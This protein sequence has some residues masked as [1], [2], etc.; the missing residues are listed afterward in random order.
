[1]MTWRAQLPDVRDIPIPVHDGDT[2]TADVDLGYHIW[3]RGQSYRLTGCNTRELAQP[4]GIEVRDALA[5]LL[6]GARVALT[7]VAP[8]KYGGRWDAVITLAD[9]S[10][11]V[12]WMVASG[13]AARW[14]GRGAK[15]VPDWPRSEQAS[16]SDHSTLVTV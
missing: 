14:N 5:D 12:D 10:D 7:S 15:P 4:G 13:W 2:L 9:G 3:L 1:M 8:D 11:L 6:I 16:S